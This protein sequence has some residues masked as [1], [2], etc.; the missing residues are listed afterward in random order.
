MNKKL[1]EHNWKPTDLKIKRATAQTE[2]VG[3]ILS[4]GM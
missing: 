1:A 2:Y 4:S 3:R